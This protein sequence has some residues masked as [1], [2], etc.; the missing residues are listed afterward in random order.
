VKIDLVDREHLIHT[1]EADRLFRHAEHHASSLV[2]G[3]SMTFCLLHSQHST[4]AICAHPGKYEALCI[5]SKTGR[6]GA[7]GYIDGRD[8]QVDS[9]AV[10]D[11][12]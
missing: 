2:L 4:C 11:R 3:Y 10:V 6:A 7:E 1:A 9:F 8:M 5:H 12:D